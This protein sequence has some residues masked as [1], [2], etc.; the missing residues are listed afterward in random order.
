MVFAVLMVI[1]ATLVPTINC[2]VM[3]QHKLAAK[4]DLLKVRHALV[5][6]ETCMTD[7]IALGERLR[8]VE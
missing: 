4:P 6:E 5:S 2:Q 3:Y 8:R 7:S 1:L